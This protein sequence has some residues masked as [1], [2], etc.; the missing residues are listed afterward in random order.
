MNTHKLVVLGITATILFSVNLA[1]QERETEGKNELQQRVDSIVQSLFHQFDEQYG[2]SIFTDET[3][4]EDREFS[5]AESEERK[6]EARRSKRRYYH[7]SSTS[8]YACCTSD[9]IR[10][11]IAPQLPWEDLPEDVLIRYNRAEG[12]FLGLSRPQR[13]DWE[14]R[15]ISVFGSGGYGFAIHRWQYELGFAQNFGIDGHS[16]MGVGVEGHNIVDSKDR[17]IVTN[18]ENS[19]AAFVLR[20]DYQNYFGREGFS[21]WTGLYNQWESADM[22]LQVAFLSDRYKSLARNTNWSIFGGD[23]VFRENPPIAEGQ[24]K[25][26]LTTLKFHSTEERWFLTRG[27]SAAASAEVAGRSLKGDFDFNQYI[28]DVRRYQPI[29]D[30]DNINVRVRAGSATGDVPPQ[31]VFE[32]GGFGTMPGFTFKEF[33]GNRMLLANVEYIVSGRLIDDFGILDDLSVLLFADAGYVATAQSNEAFTKGFE[34]LTLSS[35]KS[36]WGFGIGTRDAKVRLG[37]AWRT[38]VAEPV[39]VFLRLSRP[40]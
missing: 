33:A 34:N 37:F 4:A 10:R 21:V 38:D 12:L 5:I 6:S 31:K 24:M 13:F 1:A 30:Y 39:R 3:T 11:A 20:D 36:D 16:I 7:Y 28:V 27:W 26:L 15:R 22:Q 14:E 25:S 2:T 9:G 8:L 23:K 17:W 32:I 40:F 19:L 35:M 18:G 29:S